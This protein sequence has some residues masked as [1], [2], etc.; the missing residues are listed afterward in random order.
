M[1]TK[2]IKLLKTSR[3]WGIM[4]CVV[5]EPGEWT[6]KSIADDL[7]QGYSSIC[8]ARMSLSKQGLITFGKKSGR[9]NLLNP[10]KL[11]IQVFNR[12]IPK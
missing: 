9:G 12:S 8:D 4:N 11:G 2:K 5:S 6:T 1:I 7:S 10:T 3:R